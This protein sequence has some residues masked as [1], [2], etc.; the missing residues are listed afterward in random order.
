[1]ILKS[2]RLSVQGTD[3]LQVS[4]VR[5]V[6]MKKKKKNTTDCQNF[7]FVGNSGP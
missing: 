1:M 6:A 5:D 4:D 2:F 7:A 3:R